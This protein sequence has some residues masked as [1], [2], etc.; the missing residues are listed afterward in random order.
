[1]IVFLILLR[2]RV[3]TWLTMIVASLGVNMLSGAPLGGYLITYIWMFMLFK[4]VKTY[5]HTTDSSL[6]ISLVIISV[7]FEQLVFGM[8]YMIQSPAEII[9]S[10]VFSVTCLQVLLAGVTSPV[11]F[12]ILNKIFDVSDKLTF[13]PYHEV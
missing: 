4:N 10:Q 2:S 12:I 8:F 13:Q 1:L 9:F 11:V 6:F 3:E 7:I 5:F